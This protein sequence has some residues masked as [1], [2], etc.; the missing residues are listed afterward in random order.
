MNKFKNIWQTFLLSIIVKLYKKRKIK[1]KLSLNKHSKILLIIFRDKSETILTTPL[2]STIKQNT[3]ASISVLTSSD[4]NHIFANNPNLKQIIFNEN[5]WLKKIE[6]LTNVN[7]QEFDLI[8]NSNEQFNWDEIFWTSLV[9]S[10]FKIGFNGVEDKIFTHLVS[11][12]NISSNHFVDRSLQI[13]ESFDF[14]VEKKNLNLVYFP[15]QTSLCEIDNYLSKSFNFKKL[16]VV[17]NISGSDSRNALDCDNYKNLIKY[18]NNYEVNL[19]ISAQ[20]NELELADNIADGREQIY[21]YDDFDR[22]SALISKADFIFTHD[23]FSIQLA[24][25]FRKPIFCLFSYN[26]NNELIRVPYNSDFDFVSSDKRDFSD[27]NY[28]KVLNS[29]IPYFDYVYE[30]YCNNLFT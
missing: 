2:I 16:V 15:T 13:C 6:L 24:A 25:A 30:R 1:S 14:N 26:N 21:F 29:F 7:T 28:G 3:D 17:I 23:S 22:Y 10:K 8:I 19:I 18:I 9:K 5:N 4:S 20:Q 27:L 11:K 12:I